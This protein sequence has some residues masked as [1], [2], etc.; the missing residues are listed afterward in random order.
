MRV[1]KH[2]SV[3]IIL[4]LNKI[5]RVATFL[6][7]N[8]LADCI[9]S[10]AG[11]FPVKPMCIH[12]YFNLMHLIAMHL[13]PQYLKIRCPL[14]VTFV[15]LQSYRSPSNTVLYDAEQCQLVK[16]FPNITQFD[17]ALCLEEGQGPGSEVLWRGKLSVILSQVFAISV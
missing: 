3:T 15:S 5:N 2:D 11:G 10:N 9:T 8:Y 17:I 16:I 1:W 7:R 14:T 4:L 13:D 6:W 12:Q